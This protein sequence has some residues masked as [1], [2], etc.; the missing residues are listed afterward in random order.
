[1]HRHIEKTFNNKFNV[2]KTGQPTWIVWF[3]LLYKSKTDHNCQNQYRWLD[4]RE[5]GF[6]HFSIIYCIISD[7]IIKAINIE[8]AAKAN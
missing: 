4:P 5:P 2:L 3:S 6:K 1:M 7:P 8:P